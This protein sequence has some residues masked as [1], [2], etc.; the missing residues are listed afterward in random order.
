MPLIIIVSFVLLSFFIWK[1]N[2]KEKVFFT[3]DQNTGKPDVKIILA[4]LVLGLLYLQ[5]LRTYS[6]HRCSTAT[7]VRPQVVQSYRGRGF[8]P[9]T[10][11]SEDYYNLFSD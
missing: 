10:G 2:S 4:G 11:T 3:S 8:V 7:E 1:T 6:T 5:S 9:L